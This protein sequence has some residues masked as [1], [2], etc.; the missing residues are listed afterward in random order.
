MKWYK[1]KG[2]PNDIPDQV[3]WK[4]EQTGKVPAWRQIAKTLLKND[5]WCRNLGFGINKSSAYEK[6]L[7]LMQKRRKEWKIYE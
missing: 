6:Y 4:E 1:D 3:T 2:Y 7:A 5:Y